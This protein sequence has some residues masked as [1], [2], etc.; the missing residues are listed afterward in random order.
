MQTVARICA[1]T[2]LFCFI[3]KLKYWNQA[4]LQFDQ[5]V[6]SYYIYLFPELYNYHSFQ[7]AYLKIN[8]CYHDS[9]VRSISFLLPAIIVQSYYGVRIKFTCSGRPRL[10]WDYDC[11]S[12]SSV[13]HQGILYQGR[14]ITL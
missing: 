3:A 5:F 2:V 13:P 7:I 14:K 1:I 12:L 4:F 11:L 8:R 9:H 6:R 10:C